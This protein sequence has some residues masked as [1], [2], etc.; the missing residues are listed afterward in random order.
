MDLYRSM[1]NHICMCYAFA[2]LFLLCALLYRCFFLFERNPVV[3]NVLYFYLAIYYV[4]GVSDM[5]T[6]ILDVY[7]D[8][9][10][11]FD[12]KNEKLPVIF[13]IS[14]SLTFGTQSSSLH[15]YHFV[16]PTTNKGTIEL[17]RPE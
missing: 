8:E 12:K 5:Y 13:I 6:H 11:L 2:V 1:C 15:L 4:Y 7:T 3:R 14:L 16:L 10:H 17:D 9:T